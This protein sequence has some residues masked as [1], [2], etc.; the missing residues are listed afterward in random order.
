MNTYFKEMKTHRRSVFLRLAG[1]F[2][3]PL[4]LLISQSSCVVTC[5][6]LSATLRFKM[7]G[8]EQFPP[9]SS[10]ATGEGDITIPMCGNTFDTEVGVTF[11]GL[12]P[13]SV[14]IHSAYYGDKGLEVISLEQSQLNPNEFYGSA[15]LS[16]EQIITLTKGGYYIDAHSP[17]F[18]EGELRAQILDGYTQIAEVILEANPSV[19]A[20]SI[21]ATGRSLL[22]M[23]GSTVTG[24]LS[25]NGMIPTTAHIHRG[26]IG[27]TGLI[28]E[29]FVADENDPNFFRLPSIL[30]S[31]E[32]FD[33]L[34]RGDA[35]V[36][37]HSAL[38]PEGEVLGQVPAQ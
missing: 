23:D 6:G 10:K 11:D 31:R 38:Y 36:D 5:H 21:S 7:L 37:V 3:L 20:G 12:I 9:V 13:S 35:Y 29:T 4:L 16:K 22:T 28:L 17:E 32:E 30:L 2:I 24:N 34:K 25:V 8:A 18:P 33:L 14:H 27:Q 1:I 26:T 19:A 15:Q